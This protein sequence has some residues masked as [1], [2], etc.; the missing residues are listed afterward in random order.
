MVQDLHLGRRLPAVN[1][2]CTITPD[3][4]VVNVLLVLRR[5]KCRSQG[6]GTRGISISPNC[7]QCHQKTLLNWL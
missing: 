6:D 5:R 4:V 2:V 1:F 7:P 3:E